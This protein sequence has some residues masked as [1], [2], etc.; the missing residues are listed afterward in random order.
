MKFKLRFIG[1]IPF[2]GAILKLLLEN[3]Y[4]V[5][6]LINVVE[7]IL[8]LFIPGFISLTAEINFHHSFQILIYFNLIEN[9]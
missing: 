6:I 2:A 5:L 3:F 9:I 4:F 7:I 1:D 8:T